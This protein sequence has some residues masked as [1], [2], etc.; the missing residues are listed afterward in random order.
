MERAE[1][2]E[3]LK[4]DS[5]LYLS[6]SAAE[7]FE[8]AKERGLGALGLA[9]WARRPAWISSRVEERVGGGEGAAEEEGEE[10]GEEDAAGEGAE[11][12]VL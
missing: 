6:L 4:W 2:D 7:R 10:E 8:V 11:G 9:A 3:T 1:E 12:C 5:H